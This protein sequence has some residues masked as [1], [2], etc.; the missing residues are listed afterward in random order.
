VSGSTRRVLALAFVVLGGFAAVTTATGAPATDTT[1]ATTVAKW[2]LAIMPVA[3]S[4][5]AVTGSTS[6]AEVIRRSKKLVGVTAAAAS[7]ITA[8][9]PSTAKGRQLK[10]LAQ[11]AF[12]DFAESGK[13]LV[14]AVRDLQ[15]GRQAGVAVKLK[16]ATK[17]AGEGSALLHRAAGL[18]PRLVA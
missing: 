6:P 17:L 12:A 13:L 5:Q 4:L 11:S 18:I 7:A 10:A 8:Q 14:A 1:V 2:S 9:S 15:A 16:R 3:S